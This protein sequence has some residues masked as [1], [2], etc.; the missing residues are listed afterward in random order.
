[1]KTVR[2]Q[3]AEQRAAST[4]EYIHNLP[5]SE[6]KRR[7]VCGI[8]HLFAFVNRHRMSFDW[9][10][11]GDQIRR[12]G[13]IL[14]AHKAEGDFLPT[15]GSRDDPADVTN[16]ETAADGV[17][18]VIQVQARRKDTQENKDIQEKMTM[19][20]KAL[21]ACLTLIA[22]T[23]SASAQCVDC[24][25]YPDRD[26]LNGGVETPAAKAEHG[27]PNGAAFNNAN[28]AS[29]EFHG[30]SGTKHRKK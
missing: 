21:A 2:F 29:A 23:S 12:A 8:Y 27:A 10:P 9:L 24:A 5:K 14:G 11:A 3:I 15:D 16:C 22:L 6:T 13:R 26:H 1:V 18:R 19:I 30:H 4:G 17:F 25:M 28:N 20:Y 7:L